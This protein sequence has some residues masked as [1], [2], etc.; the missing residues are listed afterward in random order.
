MSETISLYG[1]ENDLLA[2]HLVDEPA[3]SSEKV[4]FEADEKG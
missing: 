2:L 1:K 4:E 3:V